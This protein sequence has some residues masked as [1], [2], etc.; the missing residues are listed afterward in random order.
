[1]PAALMIGHHFSISALWNAASASGVCSSRG[2]ICCP[3]LTSRSRT[4]GSASASTAAALSFA[5]ISRGIPFGANS[6]VPDGTV[7]PGQ[8]GLVHRGN[9]RGHREAAL[10][11]HCKGFDVTAAN[12]RQGRGLIRENHINLAGDETL[13]RGSAAPVGHEA[14][15]RVSLFLEEGAVDLLRTADAGR[16]SRGRVRARLQ[17]GDEALEVVRREGFPADDQ[18]HV[19]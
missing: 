1:M 15:A 3:R 12:L 4:A 10:A 6:A 16:P 2:T 11:H 13:H 7:E 14:K 17:P 8:S 9:L 5:M 19:V 18:V